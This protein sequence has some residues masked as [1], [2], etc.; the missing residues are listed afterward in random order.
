M[1]PDG[2]D[3]EY[4][5]LGPSRG[6]S[7]PGAPPRSPVYIAAYSPA[8]G[9]DFIQEDRSPYAAVDDWSAAPRLMAAEGAG[10]TTSGGSARG[11]RPKTAG[12]VA[13]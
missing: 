3:L 4:V 11:A 2:A 13:A 8:P 1:Q 9:T 7:P 6:A 5:Y 10:R 12:T